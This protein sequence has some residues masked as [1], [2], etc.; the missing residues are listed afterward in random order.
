MYMQEKHNSSKSIRSRVG[1]RLLIESFRLGH[2]ITPLGKMAMDYIEQGGGIYSVLEQMNDGFDSQQ[3]IRDLV[4]SA[5]H[6]ALTEVYLYEHKP[7]HESKVIRAKK[8]LGSLIEVWDLPQYDFLKDALP[9]KTSHSF[10]YHMLA[11]MITDIV[12]DKWAKGEQFSLYKAILEGVKSTG[13]SDQQLEDIGASLLTDILIMNRQKNQLR[14]DYWLTDILP[15]SRVPNDVIKQTAVWNFLSE[16]IRK[17]S[18][19]D[20]AFLRVFMYAKNRPDSE[21]LPLLLGL[22]YTGSGALSDLHGVLH[23]E[24]LS[25]SENQ[26]PRTIEEFAASEDD[27]Q[28]LMAAAFLARHSGVQNFS[29]GVFDQL[30]TSSNEE[31]LR[32]TL[33]GLAKWESMSE[34]RPDIRDEI[35]RRIGPLS[36]LDNPMREYVLAT[37]PMYMSVDTALRMVSYGLSHTDK[38]VRKWTDSGFQNAVAQWVLNGTLSRDN[39]QKIFRT[40]QKYKDKIEP[41]TREIILGCLKEKY[42]ALG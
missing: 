14:D 12:P 20:P 8:L 36:A 22:R 21:K 32:F 15:T 33:S 16:V 1:S 9:K 2:A 28:K 7:S 31:V 42:I 37:L 17:H 38:Q 4:H 30:L 24:M 5:A 3:N 13:V 27:M 25:V 18:Y 34:S 6:S 26:Y 35:L 10:R 11:E 19:G 23:V 39:R 40:Y 29:I 41:D